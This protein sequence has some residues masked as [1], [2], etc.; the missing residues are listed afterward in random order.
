MASYNLEDGAQ[1]WYIQVQTD[2]G[3]PTWRR[4]KELINLRYGP[5]LRSAP[6]F[7]L[8]DCR[9]T[10]TVAEYQD[11]FQALL[12]RA[13]YLDEAQRVQ[14]FTGGLLPPFSL[15]V[16]IHNP[17]SLA[18]AMSLARQLKL[19]EQYSPTPAKA[20]SRGLLP[21]PPAR[22]AMPA[23]PTDK[24]T[25][26]LITREGQQVKRLSRPKQE[27]RRRLGLC[28]NCNEK[29]TRGHNRVSRR[30]FYIGGFETTDESTTADEPDTAAPVFSLHAVT[31]VA[32]S[33]T[34]QLQVR[35][36]TTSFIAL[37]DSG[38]TH[39]FIE[40][41]AARRSGLHVEPRSRFTAMVANGERVSCLGVIRQ[42]PVVVNDAE[43]RVDL[44]VMPLAGYDVVLGA[45]WMATLGTITWDFASR[46]MAFPREGRTIRWRGV[47]PLSTP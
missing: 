5:P 29:Y 17:Q 31:G 40:E 11:R 10:S 36:G 44:Y 47:A 26:A 16:R 6:L 43:F 7:E 13:G 35:L 8:A 39:S 21:S 32:A 27:E 33:N 37:V 9:R 19:R 28:F 38:S 42:A 18:A 1:L 20:T 45:H 23:P 24:T 3:T 22:L 14:L 41:E 15:D 30:I 4:F 34:I 2:E 25:P 12:P 46:T